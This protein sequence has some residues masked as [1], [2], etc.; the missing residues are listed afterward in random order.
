MLSSIRDALF[1]APPWLSG[2]AVLLI[3]ES[4]S[5]L[6]GEGIRPSTAATICELAG[7]HPHV[8]SVTRPLSMYLGPD[9]VLV[10]L[11]VEFEPD[12]G[13]EDVASAVRSIEADIRARFPVIK[14]IYIQARD[15]G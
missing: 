10:V 11:D 3:R 12:A 1:W 8:R 9:E 7:K 13:A 14:R 2:V 15:A 5:L 4:R 6:V